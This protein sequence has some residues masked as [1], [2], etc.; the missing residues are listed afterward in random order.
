MGL[1]ERR[2]GKKGVGGLSGG[3]G[4]E[5]RFRAGRVL[6]P[7]ELSLGRVEELRRGKEQRRTRAKMVFLG[8]LRWGV[9]LVAIGVGVYFGVRFFAGLTAEEEPVGSDEAG[10]AIIDENGGTIIS[11]RVREFVRRLE[12]DAREK[13]LI[14]ERAVLP[15]GKMREVD[16]YVVGR[17]EYYRLSMERGSAEQAED[18]GRVARYLAEQGI[19]TGYVDLRVA[20]KAFYK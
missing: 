8:F 12:G 15:L 10:V 13:G 5:S 20:G 1:R 18:M 6:M 7:R 2:E 14:I 4:G 17:E 16:V 3:A 11:G 9:V 19:V